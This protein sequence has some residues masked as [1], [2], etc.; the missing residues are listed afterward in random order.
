MPSLSRRELLLSTVLAGL[1]VA[2]GRAALAGAVESPLRHL[3]RS[4]RGRLVLPGGSSYAEL[5][6]P[7]NLRFAALMPRA[8]AVCADAEDIATA[9][10][11]ARETGT[12]FAIRGGG[13]NYA[14]ASSS[15]GLIISTRAMKRARIEGSTLQAQA[16]IQ[17]S[18]LAELLPQGGG[19]TQV[20]PGGTCPNVGIAGLTLGGGIGPN[21]PWAGLTAD[22]LRQA[23]MVTADGSIVTASAHSHR[24]LFWALRGGAGGNL[25]VVT[26]LVFDL[27][28]VPVTRATTFSLTFPITSAVQTALA[29]QEVRVGHELLIGGAWSV[30]HDA[31]GTRARVRA[32]VLLSEDDARSLMAPLLAVAATSAE[33]V[34]RSWWDTYAWYRTAIS[35]PNTF[36]DRSLYAD[37]D[38]AG[39][40]ITDVVRIMQGYPGSPNGHALFALSGWVGGRVSSVGPSATAYVH[41]DARTLIEISTGWPSAVNPAAWPTPVPADVRGWMDELWESVFPHTTGE[42]YQNFPDPGLEAPLDAYYGGNLRKL[43]R[44]KSSWDPEEVFRYAQSI[45]PL[46]SS[47]ARRA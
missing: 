32:Q 25:G 21:A 18:D 28:D 45:P 26:D 40:V 43:R 4:L 29:W 27:V 7:R 10:R 44:V 6:T 36:W 33:V 22:H 16:G 46:R 17:N 11:W 1:G 30:V 37:A 47:T 31:S 34:E 24:D 38:L 12:P 19:G 3:R 13:H 20:L 9:V 39:D 41:R 5:A 23:T 2:A 15:T 14:S 35:P 42:S 8:V